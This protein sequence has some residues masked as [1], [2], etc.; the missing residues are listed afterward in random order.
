MNHFLTFT[1]I[2]HFATKPRSDKM[3]IIVKLAVK[4]ALPTMTMQAREFL[5]SFTV[6]TFVLLSG[7]LEM[8]TQLK[9]H[10]RF[11]SEE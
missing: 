10:S 1:K 7:F 3:S 11:G 8:H 9:S 6:F 5:L 4:T 2:N